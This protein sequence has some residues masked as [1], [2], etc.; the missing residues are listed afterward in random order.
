MEQAYLD[1]L[2]VETEE[3][4]KVYRTL[5]QEKKTL[6]YNMRQIAKMIE[7]AN[8]LLTSVGQKTVAF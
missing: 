3:N 1:K 2:R 6:T 4:V 5:Q 8:R 7:R